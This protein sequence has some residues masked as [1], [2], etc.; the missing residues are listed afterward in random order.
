MQ[1]IRSECSN[2][3]VNFSALGPMSQINTLFRREALNHYLT[4][5][6]LRPSISRPHLVNPAVWLLCGG[7]L[8]SSLWIP[9]PKHMIATGQVVDINQVTTT[10]PISGRIRLAAIN[11]GSEVAEGRQ[12]ATIEGDQPLKTNRGIRFLKAQLS[13]IR[14]RLTDLESEAQLAALA[15]ELKAQAL[16]KRQQLLEPRIYQS[17][18]FSEQYRE[19]LKTL[20]LAKH[21]GIITPT[22]FVSRFERA[23]MSHQ[24]SLQLKG[25]YRA[26]ASELASLPLSTRQHFLRLKTTK[27]Q[28]LETQLEVTQKLEILEDNKIHPLTAPLGG[29]IR[30]WHVADGAFVA[31]GQPIVSM[32]E[33]YPALQVSIQLPHEN[34]AQLESGRQILLTS[35]VNGGQNLSTTEGVIA[36]I[37]QFSPSL[38]GAERSPKTHGPMGL[39]TLSLGPGAEPPPGFSAG[40]WVTASIPLKGFTLARHV[41]R[42]VAEW[43]AH[44]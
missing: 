19:P 35:T 41:G 29:K 44:W 17:L 21:A 15:H 7:L 31:A 3:P 22:D 10:A 33:P 27:H 5:D 16:E 34:L 30:A 28:L 13:L 25:Q 14:E 32:S 36:R 23:A 43:V 39:L 12:I 20:R 24:Q 2:L 6:H 37:E 40:S 4:P 38:K 1:S 8:L 11:S 26:L 9:F 18:S 42:T